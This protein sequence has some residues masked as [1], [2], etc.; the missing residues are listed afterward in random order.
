MAKKTSETEIFNVTGESCTMKFIVSEIAKNLNRK[1]PNLKIPVPLLEKVF[2]ANQKTLKAGKI[3]RLAE[4]VEKWISEDVFSGEKIAGVYGFR[5][6]TSVSEG[7]RRQISEFQ[8]NRVLI[9]FG[10]LPKI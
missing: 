1:I 8:R 6:E 4:T 7:L 2:R 9:F 10:V 3:S 5:A